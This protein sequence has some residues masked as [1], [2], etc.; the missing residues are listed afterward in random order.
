MCQCCVP[1]AARVVFK[2][3]IHSTYLTLDFRFGLVAGL[4]GYMRGL[5][6]QN[7][8][9]FTD[10]LFWLSFSRLF[11]GSIVSVCVAQKTAATAGLPD[12]GTDRNPFALPSDETIF[13]FR[14]EE[15]RQ[16]EEVLSVFII[17]HIC[18]MLPSLFR[19]G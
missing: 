9:V 16:K 7:A 15:R 6:S 5:S 13:Q 19:S 3:C 2:V 12:R 8:S 14:E 10:H 18:G 17:P 11:F 4:V 1:S